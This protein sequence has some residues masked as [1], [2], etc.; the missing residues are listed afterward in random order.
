MREERG[1][2]RHV[3]ASSTSEASVAFHGQ[4]AC[5]RQS[6]HAVGL[7]VAFVSSLKKP[8]S[9]TSHK[10][11]A[12]LLDRRCRQRVQMERPDWVA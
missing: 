11:L 6:L 4:F 9:Q 7:A 5:V 1:E 8:A 10:V 2:K 3:D 12:L